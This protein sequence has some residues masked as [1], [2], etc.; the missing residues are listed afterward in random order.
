[1]KIEKLKPIFPIEVFKKVLTYPPKKYFDHLCKNVVRYKMMSGK[2]VNV[3][4]KKFDTMKISTLQKASVF[5]TLV[6]NIWEKTAQENYFI[7]NN[8]EA[9]KENSL[10]QK[11]LNAS[12]KK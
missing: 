12:I 3:W 4:K 8:L 9:N 11:L 10:S 1:M 5:D 6:K 2:D 7:K